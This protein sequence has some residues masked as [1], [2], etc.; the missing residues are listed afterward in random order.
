MKSKIDSLIDSYNSIIKQ[1]VVYDLDKTLNKTFEYDLF[2]INSCKRKL[3][4]LE[5]LDSK[6]TFEIELNSKFFIS[7]I[8][9]VEMMDN[10]N[11]KPYSYTENDNLSIYKEF[12]SS[13]ES[14]NF[15][16]IHQ[17]VKN[18]FETEDYSNFI[19][20]NNEFLREN[21][22]ENEG[23]KNESKNKNDTV[24]TNDLSKNTLFIANKFAL[25][26]SSMLLIPNPYCYFPQYISD[27]NNILLMLY[28]YNIYKNKSKEIIM[29]YNSK[30]ATSSLNHLHFQF[31]IP[32]LHYFSDSK[33]YNSNE[34]CIINFY[35]KL[36]K[37]IQEKNLLDSS[38][39]ITIVDKAKNFILEKNTRN[40]IS[41]VS[42]SFV[43]SSELEIINSLNYFGIDLDF[44]NLKKT[45]ELIYTITEKLN[46]NN[47]PYNY[48]LI[49][50]TFF[51]FPR[52]FDNYFKYSI[53]I[54]ELFGVYG[55]YCME[56]FREFDCKAFKETLF[57]MSIA[58]KVLIDFLPK[59]EL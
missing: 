7:I 53:G 27:S 14:F 30:G 54:I 37:D 8:F 55:C 45:S 34:Y 15:T 6:N 24:K 22:K 47:I 35:Y 23:N 2:D 36:L 5:N 39:R 56:E 40:K 49:N 44:E 1:E 48:L 4:T 58:K 59:N 33:Q 16:K 21:V 52:K 13:G 11:K 3:E 29:G 20:N 26:K 28:V 43:N 46:E 31:F 25:L 9:A 50:D 18:N 42:A 41:L 38:E 32:S 12:D 19:E 17:N 57:N 10:N 51:I